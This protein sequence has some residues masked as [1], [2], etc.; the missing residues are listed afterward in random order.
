MTSQ[1][2][3]VIRKLFLSSRKW[4]CMYTNILSI[5]NGIT[6][7]QLPF[8]IF[9]QTYFLSHEFI[10]IFMQF[11]IFHVLINLVLPNYSY[12]ARKKKDSK[13]ERELKI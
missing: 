11:V 13:N 10:L 8:F 3:I 6:Y 5:H 4:N 7:M 2:Q 12:D 9:D 1:L